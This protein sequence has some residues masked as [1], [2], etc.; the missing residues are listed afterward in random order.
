MYIGS[1]ALPKTV[2]YVVSK[3]AFSSP[4]IVP[5]A[6]LFMTT[7]TTGTFSSRAVASTAGFC[8]KPPSPTSET[9]T[10]SGWAILA[11][12]AAGAPKP[13]VAKPPGVRNV[14]GVRMSNC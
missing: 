13:M 7:Q 10:R 14:P 6:L 11:P 5:K 4:A 8:P 2:P 3:A 9:T 12:T 1:S